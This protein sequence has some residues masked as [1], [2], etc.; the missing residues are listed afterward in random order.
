MSSLR[1]SACPPSPGPVQAHP[2][3]L[4]VPSVPVDGLSV[5]S[6]PSQ[7]QAVLIS[8][9]PC[10]YRPTH[11]Q[12][13]LPPAQAIRGSGLDPAPSCW[14]PGQHLHAAPQSPSPQRD[15]VIQSPVP[16]DCAR[17][18]RPG[19]LRALEGPPP[20]LPAITFLLKVR[21]VPGLGEATVQEPRGVPGQHRQG[22]S[23]HRRR[24]P[25]RPPKRPP[26]PGGGRPRVA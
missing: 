4:P 12:P 17:G 19:P 26:G 22:S 21:E 16:S 25:P 5:L 6:Q 8:A 24:P 13:R 7:T 10:P 1:D 9:M 15:Q 14:S 11:P 2:H 23:W 3:R 18:A 20:G